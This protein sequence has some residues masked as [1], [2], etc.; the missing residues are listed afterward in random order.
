MGSKDE[1]YISA[2]GVLIA[3]NEIGVCGISDVSDRFTL[4]DCTRRGL[5]LASMGR[6]RREDG[7]ILQRKETG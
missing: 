6:F 7:S 4:V 2:V 1:L 3:D 5:L